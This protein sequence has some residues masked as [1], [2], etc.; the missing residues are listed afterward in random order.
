MSKTKHLEE[1]MEWWENYSST[2]AMFH[3]VRFLS[4]F[5]VVVVVLLFI[6]IIIFLFELKE[7]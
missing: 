5:V 4:V 6:Y 7:R 3:L 1:G 2:G